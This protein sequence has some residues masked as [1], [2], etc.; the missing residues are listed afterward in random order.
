MSCFCFRQVG[1]SRL[2]KV[3]YQEATNRNFA[4]DIYENADRAENEVAVGPCGGAFATFGF[5]GFLFDLRQLQGCEDCRK[6]E[7]GN[8]QKH[9]REANCIGFF[10]AQRFQLLTGSGGDVAGCCRQYQEGAEQWSNGRA[11]RVECLSERQAAG[12]C[13]RCAE[14]GDVRVRG[15]LKDCYAGCENEERT[16][17]QAVDAVGGC[18]DEEGAADRG[19]QQANDDTPFIGDAL[20][21]R[22][23]WQRYDEIGTEE[24]KL[25]EHRLRVVQRED[26]LQ[27]RNEN[28]VQAGDK[29]PHEE[30]RRQCNKSELIIVGAGLGRLR[31]SGLCA[32]V[33]KTSQFET[34]NL[35][36]A[37]MLHCGKNMPNGP[38]YAA[39][40]NR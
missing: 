33:G 29:A 10:Q 26:V 4:A 1:D 17:E 37:A 34:S 21:Q 20:N 24:A 22:T 3:V 28:V 6:H 31:A 8:R 7:E 9:V 18:R 2:R 35:R 40:A 32:V 16:E 15:D 38:L 14:F 5:N 23:R 12:C 25:N 39:S 30:Q 19:D 11:E 36:H 27:M 13:F